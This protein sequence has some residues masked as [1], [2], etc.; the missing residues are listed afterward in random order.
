[1]R[2][3]GE[4]GGAAPSPSHSGACCAAPGGRGDEVE[5]PTASR[6]P[7]CDDGDGGMEASDARASIP[8]VIIR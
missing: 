1:M 6:R 8:R 2:S 7:V 4:S 5:M 3:S